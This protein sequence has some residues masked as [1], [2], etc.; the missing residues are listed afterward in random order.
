[1]LLDKFLKYVSESTPAKYGASRIPSTSQQDD[2]LEALKIELEALH[3]NSIEI[4]NNVVLFATIEA[5]NGCKNE[6]TIGLIA[7]IDTSP[8]APSDNIKPIVHHNYGGTDLTLPHGVI[9][10]TEYPE[11]LDF[12]GDTIITS[13]GDTLL[14]ADD[15]A[16]VAILMELAEYFTQST[17]IKHGTVRLAFTTD[18]EIGKSI[19][20]FDVEKFGADF[21][22]TLDAG[23]FV[24]LE[25]ENFNAAS[26]IF[27]I[28]GRN[29]H[30]GYAY[31]RMINACEISNEIHSM[32]PKDQRPETT[33]GRDGFYHLHDMSATVDSASL[34]YIIRDFDGA[35]FNKRKQLLA[36]IANEINSKHTDSV[37]LTIEDSYFNMLKFIPQNVIDRAREAFAKCGIT[38]IEHPIRG[39]TDGARLSQ[40]GVPTPNIFN[41]GMNFHSKQE[42]C[43]LNAMQKAFEVVVAL[44]CVD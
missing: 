37:S 24:L 6:P 39:G 3:L 33:F 26:A 10:P 18:E 7:H 15:K 32:I 43:S 41:G 38:P 9:S 5:S 8:D 34:H 21:A 44:V 27:K 16:G 19:D 11:L 14:G 35:N 17:E 2:F 4:V 20:N 23:G 1:M 36:S 25:Y 12:K 22:Y 30:P 42:Y 31:H 40:L 28:K 13:S 29:I